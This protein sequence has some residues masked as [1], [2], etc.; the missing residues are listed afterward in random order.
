VH[1]FRAD[2]GSRESRLGNQV[3]AQPALRVVEDDCPVEVKSGV[4]VTFEV[5][6]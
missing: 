2:S 5:I 3:H 1:G 4:V 6:E